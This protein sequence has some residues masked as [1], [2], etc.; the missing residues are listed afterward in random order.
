MK[1]FI[2]EALLLGGFYFFV[3]Y[4]IAYFA[5][6]SA[7]L[8]DLGFITIVLFAVIVLAFKDS[9]A[10]LNAFWKRFP[11]LSLYLAALGFIKYFS[12]IFG[13][14]PGK[15]DG[16]LFATATD[17]DW[18]QS[19]LE[20]Y[21]PVYIF[22]FWVVFWIALFTATYFAFFSDI[23]LVKFVEIK[24]VEKDQPKA[25][26]KAEKTVA[27]KAKKPAA[28]KAGRKPTKKK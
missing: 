10:W 3:S 14:I 4:I 28:K 24:V 23:K 21:I 26:A 16:H 5:G 22:V 13:N 25:A 19:Y 9:F 11:K 15:V 1:P 12:I 27:K 7:W 8:W 20:A 6:N 17:V 2:R 18:Y